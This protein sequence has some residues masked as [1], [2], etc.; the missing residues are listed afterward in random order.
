MPQKRLTAPMYRPR[1]SLSRFMPETARPFE[2]C[3][4]GKML[5]VILVG[6]D[7][8]E[9]EAVR[10]VLAG[11]TLLARSARML[12]EVAPE[13]VVVSVPD[14]RL[15][16]LATAM[17][18]E[19]QVRDQNS[20][21]LE[22][23]LEQALSLVGDGFEQ[24]LAIDPLL[25]LRRAGRLAAAVRLSVR[26]GADTVFSCHRESSLLWQRTEM[27]LV[28][29]FDPTRRPGLEDSAGALPWLK[30]DGGFYLLRVDALRR[31]GSRHAGRIAPLET[32]PGEAVLA[33][34]PS[35]LSVCRVL[36]AEAAASAGAS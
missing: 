19:A 22:G 21:D 26:D 31:Y 18:L 12:G 25:P 8:R 4:V 14:E 33:D 34:T 35:G 36:M 23:A 9:A 32:E 11:E 28:P 29:Y 7:G 15:A 1:E 27:G 10:T 2:E 30:E 24:V 13:R 16:T 17:G 3:T 20:H 6:C 5:A